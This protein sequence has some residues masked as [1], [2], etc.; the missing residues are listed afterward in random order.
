MGATRKATAAAK[1]CT[2]KPTLIRFK[3]I[4]GYGPPNTTNSHDAHGLPIIV[5]Y[6]YRIMGDGCLREGI[7]LSLAP[8]PGTS[9]WRS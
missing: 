8:T 3:A 1:A 6:T 2:D 9:A 5:H 7:S 4:I